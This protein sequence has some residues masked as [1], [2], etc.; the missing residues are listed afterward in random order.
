[1]C[2]EQRIWISILSN[3]RTK[4]LVRKYLPNKC[5]ASRSY[6][7]SGGGHGSDQQGYKI[8]QTRYFGA[9]CTTLF[10]GIGGFYAYRLCEL[11]IYLFCLFFVTFF[12]SI[13][14]R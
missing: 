4:C 5:P 2:Q 9:I 7:V 6:R 14:M 3:N 12:L 1:M 8:K 10:A 11:L 13:L